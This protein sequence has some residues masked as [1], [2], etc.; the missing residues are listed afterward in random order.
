MATFGMPSISMENRDHCLMRTTELIVCKKQI[1]PFSVPCHL[2]VKKFETSVS[3]K[4]H[5]ALKH[6][7]SNPD[8]VQFLDK[9]E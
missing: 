6:R 2:C 4:K 5:F 7:E 8:I 1:M 3:L 9:I